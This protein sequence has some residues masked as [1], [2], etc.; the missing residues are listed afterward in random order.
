M[1]AAGE[2]IHGLTPRPGARAGHGLPRRLCEAPRNDDEGAA[3]AQR[4]RAHAREPQAIRRAAPEARRGRA[5]G[6]GHADG[7]LR[8]S[9]SFP[10]ACPQPVHT[11]AAGMKKPGVA[12]G[13]TACTRL[14]A[15]RDYDAGKVYYKSCRAPQPLSH[16]TRGQRRTRSSAPGETAGSW[17]T[18]AKGGDPMSH[19]SAERSASFRA[20]HYR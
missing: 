8:F 19:G 4:P 3:F 1:R 9:R 18:S 15:K 17:H 10:Q 16:C 5:R 2:G 11:C 20:R 7:R 6:G 14:A 12:P 13:R